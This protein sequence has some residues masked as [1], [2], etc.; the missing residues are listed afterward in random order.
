MASLLG[1]DEILHI[2]VG[3][4]YMPI[5]CLTTNGLSFSREVT[6]GTKT[7]C[8]LNPAGIPQKPTYEL[9]FEAIADDDETTKASYDKLK[10]EI[11]KDELTYWKITR[12]NVAIE[13]GK[14]YLTSLEKSAPVDGEV[15]FSG[16][17]TGVG[18]VVTTDQV[19][20]V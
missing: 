1:K 12:S 4:A 7:K 16:S 15:T 20:T 9:S 11:Y 10:A 3:N 2:Y 18:R 6:E 8:N 19:P 17:F 14:G 5:G 13:F